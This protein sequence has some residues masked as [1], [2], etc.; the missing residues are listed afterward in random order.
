ML[1]GKAKPEVG[2]WFMKF[3]VGEELHRLT[4]RWHQLERVL[5]RRRNRYFEHI[6][7]A[8]TGQTV[9]HVEER[10]TEHQGHGDARRR[11]RGTKF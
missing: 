8:D 9:R 4:G 1:A 11:R 7:D 3:K 6:E 5:D 10:L 2:K